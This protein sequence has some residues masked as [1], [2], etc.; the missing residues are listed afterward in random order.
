MILKVYGDKCFQKSLINRIEGDDVFFSLKERIYWETTWNCVSKKKK[1]NMKL[2]TKMLENLMKFRYLPS[3][4][5][6]W[7]AGK[8]EC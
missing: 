1:K 2:E 3:W 8:R 6:S 5:L 7:R 4:M